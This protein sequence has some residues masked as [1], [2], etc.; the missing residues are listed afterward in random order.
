[1]IQ[2]SSWGQGRNS[3]IFMWTTDAKTWIME[4]ILEQFSHAVQLLGTIA[5]P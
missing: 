2:T 5:D 3:D 1:M 4:T